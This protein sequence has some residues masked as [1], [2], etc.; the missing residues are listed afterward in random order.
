ME[1]RDQEHGQER[2]GDPEREP[3]ELPERAVGILELGVELGQ[4]LLEQRVELFV[5]LTLG[6]L[7]CLQGLLRGEYPVLSF[8]LQ[9]LKR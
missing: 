5:Q 9:F 3:L 2:Q 1:E 8:L 7:D 4:D 6:F